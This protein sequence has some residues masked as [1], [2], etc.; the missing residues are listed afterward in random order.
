VDKMR[1]TGKYLTAPAALRPEA[2]L[3]THYHVVCLT[4]SGPQSG[5]SRGLT[6]H[7]QP[8]DSMYWLL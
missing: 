7:L 6:V 5:S 4:P 3:P 8:A 2:P 1:V